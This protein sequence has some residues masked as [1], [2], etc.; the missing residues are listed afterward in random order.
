MFILVMLRDSNRCHP[1]E[2]AMFHRRALTLGSGRNSNAEFYTDL[3]SARAA[4]VG[5]VYVHETVGTIIGGIACTY[6]LVTEAL[7]ERMNQTSLENPAE[8]CE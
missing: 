6:L 2:T 7:A 4:A 5:R 1:S 3:P 8:C